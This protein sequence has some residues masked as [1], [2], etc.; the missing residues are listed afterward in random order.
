MQTMTSDRQTRLL[1]AMLSIVGA[2]LAIVGWYRWA[3]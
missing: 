1:W 3:V 2:I